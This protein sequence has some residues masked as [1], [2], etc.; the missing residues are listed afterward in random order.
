MS[1]ANNLNVSEP[2]DRGLPRLKR[3]VREHRWLIAFFIVSFFVFVV[4]GWNVGMNF[5]M[6]AWTCSTCIALI[7][8]IFWESRRKLWF[9]I[10]VSLLVVGHVIVFCC[11]HWTKQRYFGAVFKGVGMADFCLVYFIMW[12]AR[13]ISGDGWSDGSGSNGNVEPERRLD[14]LAHE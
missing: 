8:E 5:G 4:P 11:I 14:L 3:K 2:N 12:L 6:A 7:V 1:E 9:Q 13:G 10:A